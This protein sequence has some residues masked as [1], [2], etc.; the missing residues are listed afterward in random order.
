MCRRAVDVKVVFLNVLA[1]VS[2]AVREAEHAF[3]EDGVFAIPQ[4]H[5]EAQQLLV[6]ADSCKTVLAPVIRTGSGL[7]VGEVVPGISVLAVIFPNRAPLSFAEV[8]SPF[9]PRRVSCSRFFNSG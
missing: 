4:G 6:I 1:V 5:A 8:R 3:F 9:S 2:F 7:V